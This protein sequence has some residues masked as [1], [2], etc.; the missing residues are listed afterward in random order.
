MIFSC[1]FDALVNFN[2]EFLIFFFLKNVSLKKISIYF[3]ILEL[4]LSALVW[5]TV[6][7]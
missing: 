3:P 4:K 1:G 7:S 6:H 5:Y 2:E